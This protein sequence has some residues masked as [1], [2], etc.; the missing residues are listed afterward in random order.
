MYVKTFGFMH[1]KSLKRS[2]VAVNRTR[3]GS[4]R[5]SFGNSEK[6][7]HISFAFLAFVQ[8]LLGEEV[9]LL[10][11]IHASNVKRKSTRENMKL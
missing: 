4:T 9:E 10:K 7:K 6:T 1:V 8:L 2:N 11:A 3:E 5:A